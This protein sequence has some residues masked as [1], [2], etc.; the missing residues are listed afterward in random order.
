M[1]IAERLSATSLCGEKLIKA[2]VVS[3][4]WRGELPYIRS[5]ANYYL[6]Y[7]FFDKIYI[8]RCD[9]ER[10][11]L[12][13]DFQERIEFIDHPADDEKSVLAALMEF[14]LPQ[15]MDYILSCDI[16]EYLILHGKTI[17]EFIKETPADGYFFRW[18]LC[19]NV[20]EGTGDLTENLR[21]GCSVGH[22]GKSLSR[23][24][25]VDSF[26]NEHHANMKAGSRLY[27][28][29]TDVLN[30]PCILHFSSRGI[31]DLVV[32]GLWQGIKVEAQKNKYITHLDNPPPSFGR[33]PY[34]FKIAY[35]QT[36]LKKTPFRSDLPALPVDQSR[37]KDLFE[38]TGVNL[39]QSRLFEKHYCIEHIL[40]RYPHINFYDVAM[41]DSRKA[42]KM[43]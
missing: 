31:E 38:E 28:G 30:N 10:F 4:V 17:H 27:S 20:S 23:V 21:M 42:V 3:R 39:G 40:M 33:L 43:I 9:K 25:M 6:N 5:W 35:F 32:R 11:D 41:S 7:L 29:S 36:R 1:P 22:D 34:R 13:D 2:A 8:I 19:C 15:G 14:K 12:L 16:D 18:A 26:F 24:A 37:L